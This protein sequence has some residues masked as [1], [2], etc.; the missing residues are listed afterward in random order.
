[1]NPSHTYQNAGTYTVALTVSNSCGSDAMTR[2]DY[3]NVTQPSN[4]Q[5]YAIGDIPI[6]GQVTGDFTSTY[7]SDNVYEVITE[8]AYTGHPR[9]TYSYLEHKWH[10]KVNAPSW[11]DFNLEAY[12]PD[13]S[14]GDNFLF[15][16][17]TDNI[18][19]YPLVTVSS[20]SEQ[21]Y[22]VSLPDGINGDVYI[23]VTDTDRSWDKSSMDAVYI[24]EMYIEYSTSPSPPVAEFSASPTSGIVPLDVQFTDLSTNNPVAW[25]WDFGD[26]NASNL[27][28]PLH[29]YANVGTYTVSLTAT[30][31]YGNDTVT[32]TDHITVLEEG[33][34]I[35][36]QNIVVTRTVQGR[37]CTGIGT[38]YIYDSN[39]QPVS[40]AVVYAIATGPEG[41]N[42]N[43]STGSD[44]SVTFTTN[45][46]KNC[47]GEW[48]FEV[49]DVTHDTYP[50]D[51]N[52]N[53]VTLACESGDSDGP[54]SR[55]I[56]TR[57]ELLQNAPNP[58]NP[59]T[60]IIFGLPEAASVRLEI[61]NLLGNKVTTLVNGY[62][63]EGYHVINWEASS[64]SSGIYFYKLTTG[65]H[66]FTRR[67]TLLK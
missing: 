26:G 23:R 1:Q 42:F 51:P 27:Q 6:T 65:K 35:H 14:D 61:Y 54:L 62:L 17:S 12:R 48:C 34:T 20:S 53:V 29:S 25:N 64:Y 55:M 19:F 22:N 60:D 52:Q 37:N 39:N 18:T 66:V 63:P 58:F 13:N 28:N 21:V 57:F 56:P 10:F 4:E 36:V 3:I 9:K 59:V 30:N 24:D 11:A 7:S 41:G 33:M 45:K 15:E 67:M 2:V 32:K 46:S 49:T 16:Y 40:N 43:G 5:S 50:Y 38:I 47:G 31:E 44:G 8:V